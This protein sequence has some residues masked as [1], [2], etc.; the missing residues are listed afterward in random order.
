MYQIGVAGENLLLD[1][2]IHIFHT[3]SKVFIRCPKTSVE[4]FFMYH[5]FSSAA[6]VSLSVCG[7]L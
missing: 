7:F 1:T 5:I 3:L 6:F 4:S 2:K